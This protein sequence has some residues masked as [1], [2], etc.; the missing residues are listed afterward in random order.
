MEQSLQ[1]INGVPSYPIWVI[2][3]TIYSDMSEGFD[4]QLVGLF[5]D[6]PLAEKTLDELKEKVKNGEYD[7]LE[8]IQIISLELEELIINQK[9]PTLW[10]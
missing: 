2:N 1:T 7:L 9:I 4:T 10:T 5:D 8:G 6:K 3:A